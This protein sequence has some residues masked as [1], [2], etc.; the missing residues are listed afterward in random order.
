[1]AFGTTPVLA[2]VI[3][4]DLGAALIATPEVSAEGFGSARQDIGDGTL[5][6]RQHRRAMRREVGGGEAAEDVRDLDHGGAA[7][8]EAAHQSVQDTTQRDA[9]GLGQVGIDGGGGDVGVAEQDLH[10][11]GINAILEQAGRVAMPQD[12]RRHPAG[13]ARRAG[14][15]AKRGAQDRKTGR[16]GAVARWK[17]PA[18]IAMR[19]PETAQVVQK[20]RN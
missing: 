12:V 13:D 18:R 2:G 5:M 7:A 1:M 4:E 10:D 15:A 16:L 20:G 19:P 11:T 9:R 8:S 6:G 3:G 14:G 17:Q